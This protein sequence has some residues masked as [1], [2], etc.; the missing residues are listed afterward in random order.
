MKDME[1]QITMKCSVCGNDQFSA[2]N[3][4]LEDVQDAPDETEIMCSDCGK[5]TTKEQILSENS[6]L[7]EANIEDLKKDFV[8]QLE[9]D[10][11]KRFNFK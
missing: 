5:V 2:V 11:K 4:D 8:K 10:L 6:Y 9:K 3:E 7:I 1:M